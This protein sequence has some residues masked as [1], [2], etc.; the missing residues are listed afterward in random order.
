MDDEAGLSGEGS[1]DEGESGD[2]FER[3]FID[4]ASQP[5]GSIAMGY[6]SHSRACLLLPG[7]VYTAL[8]TPS[9]TD[10]DSSGHGCRRYAAC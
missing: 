2:E 3:D 6:A 7:A 4:I 9:Q 5:V 10:A 8:E 1:S